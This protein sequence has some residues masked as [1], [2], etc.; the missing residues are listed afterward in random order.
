[1]EAMTEQASLT[2]LHRKINSFGSGSKRK[3]CFGG[4]MEHGESDNE[5]E[6][7]EASQLET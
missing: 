6:E 7:E 5:E 4:S 1:M 2:T 3:L